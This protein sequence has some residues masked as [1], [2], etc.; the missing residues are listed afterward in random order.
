MLGLWGVVLMGSFVRGRGRGESRAVCL[1]VGQSVRRPGR[2][3]R[4]CAAAL[5]CW[6]CCVAG[7]LI[8]LAAAQAASAPTWRV[9]ASRSGREFYLSGVSCLSSQW[10]V[11]VGQSIGPGIALIERRNRGSWSQH[12]APAAPGG[13][14]EVLNAVSCVSQ[15]MCMAVGN[16]SN[17]VI[18]AALWNGS[19]WRYEQ[20]PGPPRGR[21]IADQSLNFVS[22]ASR[23]FCVAFGDNN[24]VHDVAESWNGSRWS[25]M[26]LPRRSFFLGLAGGVSCLSPRACL[27]VGDRLIGPIGAHVMR[28]NGRRWSVAPGLPVFVDGMSCTSLS[29]CVAVG[30]NKRARSVAARWNGRSWAVTTLPDSTRNLT[31]GGVSC[32]SASSCWAVANTGPFGDFETGERPLVWHWNGQRWSGQAIPRPSG[33]AGSDFLGIS[34]APRSPCFAVGSRTGAGGDTTTKALIERQS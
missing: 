8:C 17:G 21:F 11:A 12:A 27:A 7:L 6:C 28:W 31:L 15:T 32:P 33:A 34:C 5:R 26:R 3:R 25:L 13:S 30:I 10:C 4:W 22:C 2:W 24:R 16:N 18:A 14:I 23:S 19:R 29:N 1:V 9:E 20:P